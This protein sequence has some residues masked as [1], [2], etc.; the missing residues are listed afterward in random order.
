MLSLVVRVGVV[1]TLSKESSTS[2]VD[3]FPR[4]DVSITTDISVSLTQGVPV[5][6]FVFV[7]ST[8]IGVEGDIHS[9]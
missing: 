1:E 9:S 8:S 4:R 3:L 2:E 6:P 7:E 5:H